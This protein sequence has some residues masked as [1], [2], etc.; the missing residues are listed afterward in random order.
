MNAIAILGAVLLFVGAVVA[1]VRPAM[2]VSP[3]DEIN[4]ATRVYAGYLASR[5]MA[6]GIAL[7][8]ALLYRA[9]GALRDLML[10]Y[11]L[12]QG[13]DAAMDCVEGRWAILPGVLVLGALFLFAAL[14][15]PDRRRQLPFTTSDE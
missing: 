5:N 12:I 4:G 7:V 1:L 11:A 15:L 8:A 2:L 14:R 3:G 13:L 9:R 6:I 10:L